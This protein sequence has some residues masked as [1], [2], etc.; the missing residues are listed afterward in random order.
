MI[1]QVWRFKYIFLLEDEQLIR[2]QVYTS[3]ELI[4][5]ACCNDVNIQSCKTE[6]GWE[7]TKRPKKRKRAE[8]ESSSSKNIFKR[9]ASDE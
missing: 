4:K 2:D 7:T 9:L 6:E 8:P 1:K 5:E 3:Y